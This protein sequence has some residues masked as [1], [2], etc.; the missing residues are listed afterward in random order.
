M[1]KLLFLACMI[2]CSQVYSQNSQKKDNC[3]SKNC[4]HDKEAGCY[5][6]E[7]DCSKCQRHL[8]GTNYYNDFSPSDGIFNKVDPSTGCQEWAMLTCGNN[9][10]DNPN[11]NCKQKCNN[12]NQEAY[13]YS[14]YPRL[15]VTEGGRLGGSDKCLVMNCYPNDH[16]QTE[17]KNSRA[18]ITI[19]PTI[20]PGKTQW[21]SWS[22]KLPA[23]LGYEQDKQKCQ[24]VKHTHFIIAQLHHYPKDKKQKISSACSKNHAPPFILNLTKDKNGAGYMVGVRYGVDCEQGKNRM[25]GETAA[26]KSNFPVVLDTWYDVVLGITWSTDNAEG[27]VDLSIYNSQT[28]EIVFQSLD[29]HQANLYP[30]NANGWMPN[31]L[32]MGVYRG[33]NFCSKSSIYLDEFSMSEERKDLHCKWATLTRQIK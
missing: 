27:K 33:D 6:S 25:R 10:C 5:R 19:R 17:S 31:I 26:S 15:A 30:D 13:P 23:D 32:Q 28:G 12:M 29:N 1:K 16:I 22:F 8:T 7:D 24:G 14:K 2:M 3:V 21:F 18:E 11:F 20:V 9:C 4:I